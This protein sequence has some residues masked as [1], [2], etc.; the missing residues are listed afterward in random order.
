MSFV[1]KHDG[2]NSLLLGYEGKYGKINESLG[3]I[4]ERSDALVHTDFLSGNRA[5]AAKQYLEDVYPAIGAGF[6][7]ALE[8][9]YAA[10][11]EYNQ[12]ALGIDD[13][14]HAV[15]P[16]N[17]LV[18]RLAWAEK[19]KTLIP[20]I[21]SSGEQ[22]C[23]R[24]RDLVSL[25]RIDAEYVV[26]NAEHVIKLLK[27]VRE[28]IQ[29]NEDTYQ[30]KAAVDV[31]EL[32]DATLAFIKAQGNTKNIS[33]YS[34]AKMSSSPEYARLVKAYTVVADDIDACADKLE[35]AQETRDKLVT[36]LQ[37]EYEERLRE[38]EKA[39]FWCG[40]LCVVASVVVTVATGGAAAPAVGIIM[41]AATGALNAGV[42][43]YFDQ[44]V[45]T[46][47][48]PGKVD[49]WKVAGD[50]LIGGAVGAATSAIGMGF[51]KA[52]KSFGTV[53]KIVM[54]G[55]K[56]ATQGA[57]TDA[58]NAVGNS[59]FYGED[60]GE[61]L[62]KVVDFKKRGLEFAGGCISTGIKEGGKKL[63]EKNGWFTGKD[64]F[65]NREYEGASQVKT[66]HSATVLERAEKSLYHAGVETVASSTST[67][68]TTWIKEGDA[69][70][71]WDKV[72]DS[73]GEIFLTSATE[74]FASEMVEYH[75]ES[76]A[77][78]EQNE[79]LDKVQEAVDEETQEFN[80]KKLAKKYADMEEK[81]IKKT[82]NGGFDF[83]ESGDM[84]AQTDIE[85]TYKDP[86][87]CGGANPKQS[88]EDSSRRNDYQNAYDKMV[89]E[90]KID[91]KE[92]VMRTNSKGQ[93]TG[94]VDRI[95]PNT[96]EVLDSYTFHH[97][98]NYDVRSGK[99]TVQLVRTETHKESLGHAGSEKQIT[100][101]Y[102]EAGVRD[103]VNEYN[104][105]REKYV[106]ERKPEDRV[107]N[108]TKWAVDD[109]KRKQK[110]F[111]FTEEARE[112]QKKYEEQ[113]G[114]PQS[115]FGGERYE[116]L[117]PSYG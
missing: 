55:A 36:T 93:I 10:V 75:K 2:I 21:A 41:G 91:E 40:V 44:K 19:R 71:A 110:D 80:A 113:A 86:A 83:S 12:D 61:G 3:L 24:V 17:E 90:G 70:V 39:K 42:S 6:G 99:S 97:V 5:D 114:A 98:D 53:G 79:K 43:S 73:A 4:Q 64:G 8:G 94:G 11:L 54:G 50:A 89:K 112:E 68:T 62:S 9:L 81:G 38:A 95:D 1:Y 87:E 48:C 45:G 16:E 108:Q 7:K 37:E 29:Q 56:K 34:R 109:Q 115:G 100:Y 82:K 49:G 88:A 76:K 117:T 60:L 67:F 58:I 66:D 111:A 28:S 57:A 51:D 102:G 69:S 85:L 13:D 105:A 104:E 52:S 84:A 18:T 92:Y 106:A 65:E 63:E 23:A 78:K 26:R 35:K 77:L 14:I 33:E 32:I 96:G 25:P 116:F 31:C 22:A 46:L 101:G 72:K 30:N 103:A 47:A 59:V 74:E 27:N 15:I 20:Q 107:K